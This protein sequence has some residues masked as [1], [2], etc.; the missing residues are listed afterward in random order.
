MNRSPLN[1]SAVGSGNNRGLIFGAG[2]A[3]LTMTARLSV[4]LQRA[5][6]LTCSLVMSARMAGKRAT[7][8]RQQSSTLAVRPQLVGHV[9][10]VV[11]AS[12][13]SVLALHGS[14][15]IGTRRMGSGRVPMRLTTTAS[16]SAKHQTYAHGRAALR[17]NA[18][19]TGMDYTTTHAPTSRTA[20]IGASP[21]TA[22][23]VASGN[24][25]GA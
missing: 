17:M 3:L 7:L 6:R 11:P 25:A 18:I 15:N 1:A 24:S 5:V 10:R 20:S 12:L 4:G 8:A 14:G 13:P 2:R 19:N 22:F 9:Y 16:F 21:R 23:V